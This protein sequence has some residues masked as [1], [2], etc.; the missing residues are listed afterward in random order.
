MKITRRQLKRIIREEKAK[1]LE[2]HDPLDPFDPDAY[3]SPEHGGD[4]PVPEAEEEEAY[5]KAEEG[6]EMILD[7]LRGMSDEAAEAMISYVI[8]ELNR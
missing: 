8:H 3:T 4:V 5:M 7:A 6:L 2:Q 1:L